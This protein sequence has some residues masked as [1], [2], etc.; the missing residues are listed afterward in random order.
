MRRYKNGWLFVGLAACASAQEAPFEIRSAEPAPALTARFARTEG[1]T[2]GDGAA[3]IPLG[4][5][6]V[7]WSFADTWIGRIE[8]GRRVGPAMVNNTFALQ[9][10]EAPLEFFWKTEAGKPASVLKPEQEGAWYWPGDGVVVEGKLYLFCRLVRKQA[11]LPGFEFDVFRCDL[12]RVENPTEPPPQWRTVRLELPTALQFGAASRVEG[13]HL[14][15][16]GLFPPAQLKKLD[17]PIGVAR[18]P[19]KR[20][21]AFEAGGWEYWDGKWGERPGALFRDAAPEMSVGAVPGIPGLVATYT[22]LGLSREIMMRHASRPEGPWSKPI[23]VYRT[24]E[25]DAK[26]LIYGA[27]AHPELSR[28]EGRVLITYCRNSGSLQEHVERPDIYFPRGV[29]VRLRSR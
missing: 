1:W 2:G 15:A 11:G 5:D 12:V 17:R 4:G 9:S 22:S 20:L 25:E 23:G 14:Y 18:L 13:E 8:G 28:E 10:G 29:E 26:L 27:K 19:L 6:R 3:S 24:P 16:W 7:L 21:V